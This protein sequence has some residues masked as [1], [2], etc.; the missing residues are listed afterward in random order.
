MA[1]RED[2]MVVIQPGIWCDPCITDLVSALNAGDV[3]T[4]ASCC[5]HDRNTGSIILADGRLLTISTFEP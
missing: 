2:A 5:G 1:N 3:P 4:V